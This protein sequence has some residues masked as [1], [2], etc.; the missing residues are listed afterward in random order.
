MS[1]P[2]HIYPIA[3][4]FDSIQGEGVYTGTPMRFIRL[5]GCNVGRYEKPEAARTSA[6]SRSD[7]PLVDSGKYAT[8]ESVFG[9]RFICDTNYQMRYKSDISALLRGVYQHHICL[10]GGEPF[11]HDLRPFLEECLTRDIMVHI[12][13]SG[14]HDICQ[15]L[16]GLFSAGNVWITCSPKRGFLR[17]NLHVVSEWKFVVTAGV[18]VSVIE[19]FFDYPQGPSPRVNRRPIFLQPVNNI[20]T[21]D[22]ESVANV[23]GM[24]DRRPEWRLSVQM[25]KY[26]ELR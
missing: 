6:Q 18:S 21:V 2:E 1:T 4:E 26:L 11:M 14:S 12:E 20:N 3:E 8:C 9:E 19:K 17:Q 24:L 25:H 16:D 22:R 23:L 15:K 10:T 7:F 5:A 13:T